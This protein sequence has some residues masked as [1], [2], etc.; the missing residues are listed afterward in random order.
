MQ[1]KKYDLVCNG[2]ELSSG[3]VRNHDPEIMIKAFD[4]AGYTKETI[5]NKLSVFYAMDKI[6]DEEYSTLTLLTEE[7]YTVVEEEEGVE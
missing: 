1:T 2:I 7:K 4:I 5:E 3:A 6:T